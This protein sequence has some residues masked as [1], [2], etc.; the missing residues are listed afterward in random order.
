MENTGADRGTLLLKHENRWVIQ[1]RGDIKTKE[2]AV[3]INQPYMSGRAEKEEESIP[4]SVINFCIRSKE[5]VVVNNPLLNSRFAVDKY[6]QK[7]KTKSILCVPMLN[8]GELNGVLYLE[9]RP[10]HFVMAL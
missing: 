5:A 1:A 4:G 10:V 8:G 7:N 9:N 6:I 2:Y 3:L